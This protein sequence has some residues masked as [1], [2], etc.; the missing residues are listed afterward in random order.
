M[1]VKEWTG[2]FSDIIKKAW[3]NH[4]GSREKIYIEFFFYMT[5]VYGSLSSRPV[6]EKMEISFGIFLWEIEI[7]S[8]INAK[9]DF[10][11]NKEIAIWLVY[12]SVL[13]L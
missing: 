11:K 7:C 1:N 6:E 8:I 5:S 4:F 12:I 9:P 10:K 13:T 3:A 2:Y